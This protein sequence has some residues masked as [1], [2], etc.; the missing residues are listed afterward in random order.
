MTAVPPITGIAEIVLNVRDLPRMRQFYKSVLGFELM[1]QAC[2]ETGWEP[3]PDGNPTIA[4][5]TV[6]K[7]DTPLGHHGHPQLL[8][9]IDF[10][11]H[12]F[13][14]ERFDG[15]EPRRS[16]LNHLAF[17]IPPDSYRVHEERLES[18]GLDP[19]TVEFPNM[20]ARALFFRDPEGN[21]LELICHH[22]T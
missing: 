7:L 10:Q 6:K 9:L 12:V 3:D 5:L 19:R 15:H 20:K 22:E 2:H 11:R 4:F 8:V 17:E 1:S 21:T 13:A 18:A 14:K 16:T